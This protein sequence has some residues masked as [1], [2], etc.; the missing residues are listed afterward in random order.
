MTELV[1]SSKKLFKE[2]FGREMEEGDPL[3][4]DPDI[5]DKPTPINPD[6][7]IK[8]MVE[9]LKQ[10]GMP[11]EYI[12]A[13]E[14]TKG[15]MRNPLNEHLLSEKDKQEWDDAIASYWAMQKVKREEPKQ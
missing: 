1:K 12:Y 7:M 10:A 13:Y 6:K 11:P 9:I 14:Q 4:F 5:K 3:I 2:T 15:L 8:Q